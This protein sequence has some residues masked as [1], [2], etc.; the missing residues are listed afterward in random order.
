MQNLSSG[1]SHIYK[2][3]GTLAGGVGFQRIVQW[4]EGN[5]YALFTTTL[6]NNTTAALSNVATLDNQDPDPGGTFNTNNDVTSGNAL[7]AGSNTFGAMALGSA[8]SRRV[9]SAEGF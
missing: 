2:I 1:T 5:N 8:D 3:T 9:V 6:T 7:V 4:T